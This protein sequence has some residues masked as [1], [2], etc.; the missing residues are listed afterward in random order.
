VSGLLVFGSI[1]ARARRP[2]VGLLW[3]VSALGFVLGLA[4][5]GAIDST[6]LL[7]ETAAKAA[8]LHGPQSMLLRLLPVWALVT[9]FLV[10]SEI[11]DAYESRFG[12]LRLQAPPLPPDPRSSKHVVLGSGKSPIEADVSSIVLVSAEE[13]YCRVVIFGQGGISSTLAKYLGSE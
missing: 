12:A 2:T 13:N 6:G 5:V 8:S 7:A 4:L 1:R 10:R 9:A 11:L 3:L